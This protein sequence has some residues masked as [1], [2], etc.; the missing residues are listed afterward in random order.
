[1]ESHKPKN[2]HIANLCLKSLLD[3][4]ISL[5]NHHIS[6]A[7]LSGTFQFQYKHHVSGTLFQSTS[8]FLL[9]HFVCKQIAFSHFTFYMSLETFSLQHLTISVH[10]NRDDVIRC[11]KAVSVFV[12]E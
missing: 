4:I 10:D 6:Y 3:F 8:R 5:R 11:E 1:M 7:N 12:V 9:F 2:I